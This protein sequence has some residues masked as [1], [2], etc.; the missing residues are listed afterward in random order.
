[1]PCQAYPPSN[2]RPNTFS[3]AVTAAFTPCAPGAELPRYALLATIETYVNGG[4]AML[5]VHERLWIRGRHTWSYLT[6][7]LSALSFS[8]ALTLLLISWSDELSHARSRAA[9][10]MRRRSLAISFSTL[11]ATAAAM[12]IAWAASD[13]EAET[14]FVEPYGATLSW[15][16]RAS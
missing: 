6:L 12:S 15:L 16:V 9:L 5:A 2:W 3:F 1:M 14:A 13:A 11:A 7:V 4:E 8:L 10:L